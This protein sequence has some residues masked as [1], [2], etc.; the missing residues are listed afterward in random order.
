M[1]VAILNNSGK[2]KEAVLNTLIPMGFIGVVYIIYSLLLPTLY[3]IYIDSVSSIAAAFLV[4]YLYPFIDLIIYS[5]MLILG[6]YVEDRVKNFYGVIHF[7]LLG[8]GVGLTL[9]VGYTEV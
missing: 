2:T 4:F 3:K 5:L 7:I 8:Y 9:L 6:N 1:I